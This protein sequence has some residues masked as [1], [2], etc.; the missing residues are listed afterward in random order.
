MR[1]QTV[2]AILFFPPIR[3]PYPGVRTATPSIGF[4]DCWSW[5]ARLSAWENRRAIFCVELDL[6]VWEFL[7]M[8]GL[9]VVAL[10]NN[11]LKAKIVQS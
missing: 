4:L 8:L 6:G 1:S 11:Q 3:K 7:G 5:V 2:T 9:I 10:F